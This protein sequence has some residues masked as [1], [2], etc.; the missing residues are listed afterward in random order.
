VP[1]YNVFDVTTRHILPQFFHNV[2]E[3]KSS[4]SRTVRKK[5]SRRK[6]RNRTTGAADHL[7]NEPP[8][9]DRRI[10]LGSNHIL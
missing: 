5:V 1:V 9:V 2:V 7:N 6:S 8:L 10:S 4:V 3:R